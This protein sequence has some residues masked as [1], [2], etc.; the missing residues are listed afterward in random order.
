MPEFFKKFKIKN[1][2]LKLKFKLKLKLTRHDYRK[3][4]E[5]LFKKHHE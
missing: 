2:K 5:S 1:L 4:C 3:K